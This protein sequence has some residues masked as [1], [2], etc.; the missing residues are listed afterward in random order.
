MIIAWSESIVSSSIS[1]SHES[2]QS[3]A[4]E[5]FSAPCISRTVFPPIVIPSSITSLVSPSVRVL[6]SIAFELYTSMTFRLFISSLCSHADSGLREMIS[7]M[8]ASIFGMSM[9]LV[10]I[11]MRVLYRKNSKNP[12]NLHRNLPHLPDHPIQFLDIVPEFYHE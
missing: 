4:R 3:I 1:F 11:G 7:F 2:I 12:R 10:G 6:P 9:S 5:R 8:R